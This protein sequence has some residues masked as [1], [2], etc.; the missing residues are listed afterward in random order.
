MALNV[1]HTE[2]LDTTHGAQAAGSLAE[3]LDHVVCNQHG[4]DV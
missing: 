1:I 3:V 2:D 4:A